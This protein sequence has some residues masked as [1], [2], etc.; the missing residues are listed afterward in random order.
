MKTNS[1][2]EFLFTYSKPARERGDDT[3]IILYGLAWAYIGTMFVFTQNLYLEMAMSKY[4]YFDVLCVL[5]IIL[6][7]WRSSNKKIDL[8]HSD[9][10]PSLLTTVVFSLIILIIVSLFLDSATGLLSDESIFQFARVIPTEELLFRGLA[11]ELFLL[12]DNRSP[13]QFTTENKS[14]ASLLARNKFF[15]VGGIC[16]SILF[17]ALHNDAYEGNIIPIVYLTI[18][19]LFCAFNRYKHGL[20]AAILLHALNNLAALG[21]ASL[22]ALTIII[23]QGIAIAVSAITHYTRR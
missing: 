20:I 3:G 9:D 23:L 11:L 17:G 6:F 8:V 7:L 10:I 5:F 16:S 18:L 1:V 13:S 4:I 15:I 2:K 12:M 19:G 22:T 21:Q 14:I